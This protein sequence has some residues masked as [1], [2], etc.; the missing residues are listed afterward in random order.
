[1]NY[2]FPATKWAKID[3]NLV[4]QARSIELEFQEFLNEEPETEEEIM[5]L[6]DLIQS[7]E[8]Y[9][10]IIEARGCD[11]DA[12]FEKVKQKNEARGYYDTEIPELFNHS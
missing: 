7:C 10:R 12:A 4:E 2:I 11:I 1:M 9:L 8:T 6:L 5:E 3:T